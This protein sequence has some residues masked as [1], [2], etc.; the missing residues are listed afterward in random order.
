MPVVNLEKF[1]L[2]QFMPYFLLF[3]W[4]NKIRNRMWW[5]EPQQKIYFDAIEGD[6]WH[7]TSKMFD[8]K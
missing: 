2:E 4:R 6:V 7:C 8:R 1:L 5:F 3:T